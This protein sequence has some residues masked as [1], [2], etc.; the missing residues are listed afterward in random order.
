ME[1]S[2]NLFYSSCMPA[3]ELPADTKRTTL[4]EMEE[5]E[6]DDVDGDDDNDDAE[7]EEEVEK[8]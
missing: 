1:N 8:A 5:D 2:E 3:G 4:K 6:K 7:E